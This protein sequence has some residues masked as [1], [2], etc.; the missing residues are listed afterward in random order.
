VRVVA[1]EVAAAWQYD[2]ELQT[3]RAR[4][5]RFFVVISATRCIFWG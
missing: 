1:G 2:F 3:H 5:Y 4:G